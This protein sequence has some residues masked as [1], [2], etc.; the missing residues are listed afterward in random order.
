M[1]YTTIQNWSNNVYNLV[2]KRAKAQ[3]D[4]TVGVDRRELRSQ[5]NHGSTHLF[6]W[7]EKGRVGPCC[8]LPL[9]MRSPTPDTGAK[10][11]P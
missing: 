1:R 6:I 4:A 8:P 3:K 7:M 11:I 9:R 5:D 2:T 10:M